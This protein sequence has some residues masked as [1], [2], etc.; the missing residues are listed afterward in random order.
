[1]NTVILALA[2]IGDGGSLDMW[3]MG[4]ATADV[5]VYAY[6]KP[7]P[8]VSVSVTRE[9]PKITYQVV[10]AYYP[11]RGGW[12]TGCPNWTH[13]TIGEHTGK[14]DHAWLAALSNAEVQ[15][16]HSDDHEGRVKWAYA[17]RPGQWVSRVA[18]RQ[19]PTEY[20]S[21]TV[22]QSAPLY[23]VVEPIPMTKKEIR[24]AKKAEKAIGRAVYGTR[25]GKHP[26]RV[27]SWL[28]GS[29]G[30][31]RYRSSYCPTGNCPW[32]N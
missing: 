15:S 1:M 28:R 5:P 20:V 17:K 23:A 10:D 14:F 19:Q 12:W 7:K 9:V 16:L 32:A 11:I 31:P 3:A 4:S 26:G 29:F 25:D 24:E 6:V 30:D 22:Y 13:L 27:G 18:V 2:L 8:F 21:T